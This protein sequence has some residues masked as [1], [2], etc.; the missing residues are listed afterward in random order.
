[1]VVQWSQWQPMKSDEIEYVF[2][3]YIRMLF[4]VT[5]V[6]FGFYV[7]MYLSLDGINLYQW[8]CFIW[9]TNMCI[10]AMFV[11]YLYPAHRGWLCAQKNPNKSGLIS[12][13]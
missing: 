7:Y 13:N 1:M 11:P 5:I 10:V 6:T 12:G 4:L 8:E 3:I 2:I 9:M